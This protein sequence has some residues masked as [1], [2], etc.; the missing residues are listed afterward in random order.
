MLTILSDSRE[1]LPLNFVGLEG[2]DKVETIGLP[3][4]DYTAM[5]DGRQVPIC[6]DRKNLGDLYGTMTSGYERFKREMA[7]AKEVG[8]K[9]ILI[10]EDTYSEVLEGYSHSEY[11]GESMIKKLQTLRIKYD[12]EWWPCTSRQEMAHQI[13]STF[14]A[15]GRFW[16]KS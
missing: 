14:L 4:G 12:L 5:I 13:A 6:F 16:S 11:S 3:F 2:V 15:V 10:T 7:R 9:L 8:H 1:Q